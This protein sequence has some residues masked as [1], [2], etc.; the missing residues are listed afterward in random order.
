MSYSERLLKLKIIK[1]FKKT[2]NKY[3]LLF[4]YLYEF[5]VDFLF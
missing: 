2:L 4:N 5:I 3:L 1:Y